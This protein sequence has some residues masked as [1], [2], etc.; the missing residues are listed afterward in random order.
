MSAKPKPS[1]ILAICLFCIGVALSLGA[2]A[3]TCQQQCY[4]SYVNCIESGTLPLYKCQQI[5]NTCV[6]QCG[7]SVR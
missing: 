2:Y 6:N 1:T 3:Y 4:V 7:G 5:Y